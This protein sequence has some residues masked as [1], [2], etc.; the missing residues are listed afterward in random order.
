MIFGIKEK[1]ILTY[2]ELLAIATNIPVLLITGFVVQGHIFVQDTGGNVSQRDIFDS[3]TATRGGWSLERV[4][5]SYTLCALQ[6]PSNVK[7]CLAALAFN[8]E[9]VCDIMFR[10]FHI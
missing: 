10:L 3:V 1:S 4:H 6:P 8:K 9:C 7:N 5:V 2:N